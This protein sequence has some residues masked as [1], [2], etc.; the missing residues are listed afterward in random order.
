MARMVAFA[1]QK[2]GVGKTVMAQAFAVHIAGKRSN[3]LKPVLM[4]DL[5]IGQRSTMEWVE[6]RKQ[7]GFKPVINAT[8][9]DP[10][11]HVDFGASLIA[12]DNGLIIAD[13][14]GWSDEKSLRLAGF[15]DLMVLPTGA[16]L[17][18]LRPTI[19][20]M[21][22][23][24]DQGMTTD[25]VLIGLCKVA[26]KREEREARG[27]L[28]DA[29]YEALPSMIRESVAVRD[30]QDLGQS[31]LEAGNDLLRNGAG[32]MI[33]AI[34]TALTQ[35]IKRMTKQPHKFE[36]KADRFKLE[37]ENEGR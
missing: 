30:L 21:H 8:L 37:S 6:A 19:R 31:V 18:D 12:Q 24:T 14:A 20:L 7:N 4:A 27:Y 25:R 9:V 2:G 36:L 13:A 17:A 16:S 5:D 28:N 11:L 23:L 3:K 35:Q 29:G 22:E 10:E 1:S 32:K 15:S 34:D 26:N 33:G